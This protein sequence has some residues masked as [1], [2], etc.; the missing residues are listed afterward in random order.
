MAVFGARRTSSKVLILVAL[1]EGTHSRDGQLRR[2]AEVVLLTTQF[3]GVTLSNLPKQCLCRFDDDGKPTQLVTELPHGL[4]LLHLDAEEL[5]GEV[6]IPD[7][8]RF[9]GL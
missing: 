6:Q 7:S 9:P 1:V 4:A 8:Q 3:S 5:V 2:D